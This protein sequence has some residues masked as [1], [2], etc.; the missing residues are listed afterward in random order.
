MRRAGRYDLVTLDMGFTLVDL[1]SGVNRMLLDV[2]RRVRPELTLDEVHIAQSQFWDAWNLMEAE[3]VWEPSP[4]ADRAAGREIDAGI[5]HLLGVDDPAIIDEVNAETRRRYSDIATYTIFPDA[6]PALEALR[7]S[8]PVLG[9]VSN[10]GWHL[11][12]LCVS[13]GLDRHVDFIVASARVGAAK[14]N[15]KIFRHALAMCSCAPERALHVG[16]SL[17]A[18]VRGAEAVGMTGVL[19]DRS[20]S[21]NEV[22]CPVVQK[23]TALPPLLR[24]AGR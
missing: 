17:V 23:L 6:I 1:H 8:V 5:L 18:D 7:A 24:Q 22:G 2:G 10:W 4:A 19:L 3:Q 12:E 14:P 20:G 15:A 11:P 21:S 13:L 16:D 9:I